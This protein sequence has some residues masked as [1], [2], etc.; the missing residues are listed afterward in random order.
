M[1]RHAL[2]LGKCDIYK[3]VGSVFSRTLLEKEM[4]PLELC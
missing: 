4:K 3:T 1:L 2:F